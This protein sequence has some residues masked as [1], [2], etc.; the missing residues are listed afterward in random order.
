LP[1]L[2]A[3]QIGTGLLLTDALGWLPGLGG[4]VGLVLVVAP[5]AA[6]IVLLGASLWRRPVPV[7]RAR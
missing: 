4:S 3:F 7:T 5:M 1:R 6:S 2:L